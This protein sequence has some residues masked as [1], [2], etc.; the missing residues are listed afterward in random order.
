MRFV[1]I[2]VSH[3]EPGI[4]KLLFVLVQLSLPTLRKSLVGVMAFL[5]K[6]TRA[7]LLHA[8]A[9]RYAVALVLEM[10]AISVVGQWKSAIIRKQ[11]SG[12]RSVSVSASSLLKLLVR[13]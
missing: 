6:C 1:S 11:P 7:A 10:L 5:P 2:G 12:F 3:V 13:R 8:Q 9:C 4:T